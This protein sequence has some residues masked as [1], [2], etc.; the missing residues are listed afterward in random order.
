MSTSLSCRL[1]H[2]PGAR[3]AA[4]TEA[5]RLGRLL[6]EP[7]GDEGLKVEEAREF[8]LLMQCPPVGEDCGVVIAGPLDH[9]APKS[10]DVLLKSVEEPPPYVHPLLWATD[11]G[12]VSATIRS[13]CLPVWC[14][15][16][17]HQVGDDELEG[18]ARELLNAVLAGRLD[19]VPVLV[20]KV[21]STPKQRGRETELVAEVVEAM[22]VMLD[23]PKVL[24]LWDR[25]RELATWRNPTQVEVM[26]A[27]LFEG[28]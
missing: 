6:H 7:F 5:S 8:V 21:K 15:V 22:T 18:T 1:Y 16:G 9:A 20:A 26:S 27:F 19:Q 13:R 4:L 10:S 14:P 25:V 3:Q 24:A 2:G 23:N 12:G 17:P 28:E 11:L